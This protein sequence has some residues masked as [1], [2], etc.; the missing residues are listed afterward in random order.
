METLNGAILC[1]LW[2][3][4]NGFEYTYNEPDLGEVY[5]MFRTL[6]NDAILEWIKALA[7]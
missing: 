1:N 7:K 4:I 5:Y 6:R 3:S 2:D